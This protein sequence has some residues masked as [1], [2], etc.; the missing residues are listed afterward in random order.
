MDDTTTTDVTADGYEA[1]VLTEYG[2]ITEWTH[3][4]FAEAVNVSV[5]F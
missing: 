5:I 1:P 3:G 4:A 2:S